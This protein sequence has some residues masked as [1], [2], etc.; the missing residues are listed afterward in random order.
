MVNAAFFHFVNRKSRKLYFIGYFTSILEPFKLL[1]PWCLS[2]HRDLRLSSLCSLW[3]CFMIRLDPA[4]PNHR[5]MTSWTGRRFIVLS[6]YSFG[7][8]S[9]TL[10]FFSLQLTFLCNYFA[11]R[12][13]ILGLFGF[14]IRMVVSIT[15]LFHI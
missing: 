5:S 2:C 8:W 7:L 1:L 14:Y 6:F 4:L 11:Y 3:S 10:H 13:S 12:P 9:L 15:N